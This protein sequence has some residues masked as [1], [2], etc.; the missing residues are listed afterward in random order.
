MEV[1]PEAAKQSEPA[2]QE[3]GCVCFD[4]LEPVRVEYIEVVETVQIT[5]NENFKEIQP[6]LKNSPDATTTATR[7]LLSR[8][9]K[10][11]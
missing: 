11:N 6:P 3:F 8:N 5:E 7:R 4:E 1:C 9:R 10:K 2:G